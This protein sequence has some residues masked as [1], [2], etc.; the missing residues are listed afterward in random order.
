MRSRG[1]PPYAK[2]SASS[3]ARVARRDER[4]ERGD[5][6]LEVDVPDPRD[7]AAVGDL[8]VERDHGDARRSAV[9]ERA[10][11]LVGAGRVLDQQHQQAAVADRDPLE[12]AEG[13]RE[14][15]QAGGDL[16]ERQAERE[17]ERRGAERV[18]DVVEAGQR[19][20]DPCASPSGAWSVKEAPSSP[21]SSMSRATTSSGGRA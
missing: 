5:E 19:E 13:G 15:A 17:R 21:R 16:G 6:R 9:D 20:L 1:R 3:A 8:V 11:D 12:A 14:A 4:L 18:V 7:V 2:R 10:H